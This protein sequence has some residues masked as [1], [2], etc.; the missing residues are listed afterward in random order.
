MA[1]FISFEGPDGSGKSTQARRLGE[2]FRARGRSL[3][4]VREP[5]STPLGERVRTLLLDPESPPATPLVM[6]FLLS[7]SRAQLVTDVIKPALAG[8][9]SVIV[10]RYADSTIAYQCYGAGLDIDTARTLEEIATGGVRPDARVYVDVPTEV[11]LARVS[12]RGAA[13]RLDQETV[14]FHQRVRE[15]Y[16]QM[17]DENPAR[18]IVVDGS[19]SPDTVHCQI[20]QSLTPMLSK[21]CGA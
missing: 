20:V 12:S 15:G 21:E 16:L 1:L 19:Q 9:K 10:D 7:A 2:C 18:W 6:A 8:G 11:G 13:N 17:I 14:A 3:V 5:G 4:E